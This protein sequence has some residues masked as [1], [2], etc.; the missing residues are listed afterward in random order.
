[1]YTNQISHTFAPRIKFRRYCTV[2]RIGGQ[3]LNEA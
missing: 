2:D 3:Q 1:M